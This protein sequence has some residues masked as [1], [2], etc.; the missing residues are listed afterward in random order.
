M[1]FMVAI[2]LFI[3]WFACTSVI[4]FTTT[5]TT[6]PEVTDVTIEENID[7]YTTRPD[8]AHLEEI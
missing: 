8:E 7:G 1:R 3:V 2:D 4:A 6:P 5:Q